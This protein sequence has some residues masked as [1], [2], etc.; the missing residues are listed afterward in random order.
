MRYPIALPFY[1]PEDIREILTQ[2]EG[3]LKGDAMMTMSKNVA[4]FEKEFAA[5]VGAKH[6]IAANSCT[7]ALESTLASLHIGPGDEVI[8]PAQTFIATGS[9]VAALGATPVFCEVGADFL[10]DFE[11]LKRRLTDN[12]KAVIIVHFLG[13]IHPQID[14]IRE[15]LQGRDVYLV[16]D[17][18]HAHGA[19]RGA[20]KAGAF[21]DA[22]CF[23]FFSTKI[24][25]VGE[26]GMVT[27]DNDTIADTIRSVRNR[28][29]DGKA[30][31]EI[32]SRLG[33][34][35]RMTEFQAI[36][37]RYQLRRL[38]SFVAHRNEIGDVYRS[39]LE[40]LSEK[41]TISF[42]QSTPG[43]C[44]SFWKFPVVIESSTLSR[45]SIKNRMRSHEVEVDWPYEPL[46]HLQP[47]FRK[48][49]GCNQGMLPQSE[50][51]CKRHFCLPV[52]VGIEE[53]D[54]LFISEK[55][56]DTLA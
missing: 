41:R 50:A 46:L 23:S 2:F 9:C 8:V 22:A 6:A 18:A 39:A 33:S 42:P 37:G 40:P 25:A 47:V 12:T 51:L 54:A 20:T 17:A 1:P 34:N 52:H 49:L 56:I 28:G 24:L 21:G 15:Y 11:D 43:G 10:L 3:I 32:F 13:L 36:M 53:R 27:T 38:D 35:R 26:G 14:E 4:A 44:H 19:S 29:L 31:K 5:Y 48:L 30:G 55:L 16:E 45:E 7:G